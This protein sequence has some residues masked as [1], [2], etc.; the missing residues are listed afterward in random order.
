[1]N[2]N[3]YHYGSIN[4]WQKGALLNRIMGQTDRQTDRQTSEYF[5]FFDNVRDEVIAL[6]GIGI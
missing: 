6:F 3:H 4:A 2:N 5:A 1:M